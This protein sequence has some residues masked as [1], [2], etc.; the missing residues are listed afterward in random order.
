MN[1]AHDVTWSPDGSCLAVWEGPL[2]YKL[3]ILLASGEFY[4]QRFGS[5]RTRKQR[6]GHADRC[7]H[8][9]PSSSFEASKRVCGCA[10]FS[11]RRWKRDSTGRL[12]SVVL[13]LAVGAGDEK[14]RIL[15]STEWEEVACLDLSSSSIRASKDTAA[16]PVYGPLI[17]WR[18][19][20]SWLEE[21]R[22][23]G[24]VALEQAS[25]PFSLSASKSDTSRPNTRA[26]IAW[27]AWSP[28]GNLLAAFNDRLPNAVWIYAFSEPG[29]SE[30]RVFGKKPR[31]L[32]VLQLNSTARKVC[33]RSGHVGK[34]A[35]YAITARSTHGN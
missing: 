25:L 35:W 22:G 16:L 7:R 21:T 26:G 29:S 12:A 18:E 6:A 23:R 30:G 4:E 9:N 3:Q 8:R 10:Q 2:E 14:V 32:A 19:P 15:E 20:S 33:W 11:S 24:I 34:S 31:L 17:A 27:M 13:F 5:S 1:D 28:E